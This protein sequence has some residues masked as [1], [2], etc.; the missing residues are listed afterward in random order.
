MADVT[1]PSGRATGG[2]VSSQRGLGADR[3]DEAETIDTAASM[4]RSAIAIRATKR[5]D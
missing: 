5:R 1:A 4:N 2:T 3:R